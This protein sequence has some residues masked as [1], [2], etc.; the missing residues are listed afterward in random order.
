VDDTDR[1]KKKV[2]RLEGLLAVTRAMSQVRNINDL[3]DMIATEA[4]RLMEADRSSIFLVTRDGEE[5]ASEVALGVDGER[6][7]IDKLGGIAG[8]VYQT[9]ETVNIEDA[10]RD[11]RFEKSVDRKTGFRT[12]SVLTVPLLGPKGKRIGVFQVLN[13]REGFFS[14]EDEELAH[15]FATQATVAIMNAQEYEH[16]YKEKTR[17]LRQFKKDFSLDK[18]IGV[19]SQMEELKNLARKVAAS[20]ASVLITGS[21]GTGK[22]L[23]AKAIHAESDRAEGPFVAINCAALPESLL[24]SELFGIEKGVATG[25]EERPGK[26]EAAHKGSLLLDEIGDM[27]LPMQANLLRVL[28]EREVE[29]I[30]SRKPKPV[31]IRVIAASNRDLEQLVK[32]GKFREDL[33]FRLNVISI[34]IP[35]L[36]E[37]RDDIPVLA[38]YFLQQAS[39]KYSRKWTGFTPEAAE[40]LKNHDWPGNVRELENVIERA[41]ALSGEDQIGIKDLSGKLNNGGPEAECKGVTIAEAVSGFERKLIESTL[42]GS[43]GNRTLAAEKLG[44]SREGLRKKMKRYNIE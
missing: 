41:C 13:K 15:A 7:K 17:L 37:R 19:S 21:S 28:Q 16:L 3:L 25:V 2:E 18:M 4:A 11:K 31:D 35:A 8:H 14:N 39:K 40:V 30:G 22:D 43:D 9:G 44:L 5:L 20:Q 23:L 29:R 38:G 27:P 32:D 36:K 1:L 33:Y 24:E 12:R 34:S 6:I 42:A 26:I 10:Y